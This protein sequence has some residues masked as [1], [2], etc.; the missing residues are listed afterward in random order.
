M[1]SLNISVCAYF[2][3]YTVLYLGTVRIRTLI[4]LDYDFQDSLDQCQKYTLWIPMPINKD[5]GRSI[6]F[7]IIHWEELR[8]IEWYWALIDQ[9]W[10]VFWSVL[11][12]IWHWSRESWISFTCIYFMLMCFN[13]IFTIL[14]LP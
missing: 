10:S 12:N 6:L 7:N 9:Y 1:C 2:W 4:I 5:Q 8:R 13:G 11:I 14:Y 3:V